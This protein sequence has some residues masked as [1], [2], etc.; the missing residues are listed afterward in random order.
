MYYILR[1][2]AEEYASR[3][4]SAGEITLNEYNAQKDSALFRKSMK[5]DKIAREY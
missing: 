3:E 1:Y 2:A 5:S 4:K